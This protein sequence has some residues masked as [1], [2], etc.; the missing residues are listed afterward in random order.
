MRQINYK[1]PRTL[2]IILLVVLLI[3]AN[4]NANYKIVGNSELSAHSHFGWA[5][6]LD[7]GLSFIS[8][9][10]EDNEKGMDV[11]AVYTFNTNG[12]LQQKIIPESIKPYDNF[13]YSVSH[14]GTIAIVGAIG[15][16]TNGTFSGCVY[17]YRYDGQKWIEEQKL[18]ASDGQASDLFGCSVDIKG[19]IAVVGSRQS[20]G[21]TSKSGAAYIFEFD[22]TNWK[23]V[24]KLISS[25]SSPNDIFGHSVAINEDEVVVVG[26]YSNSG[27]ENNSGS[28]YI[29]E[30][31]QS[32]WSKTAKLVASD[33]KTSDLFGFSVAIS[34]NNILVGAYQNQLNNK[35]HG[36]V[37]VYTKSETSW[38]ETA[39]LVLEDG[40]E[41]DFFGI[42]VAIS[43][44]VIAIGSSRTETE[45]NKDVGSVHIYSLDSGTWINKSIL[46]PEIEQNNVQFGLAIDI[47]AGNTLVGSCLNDNEA[48]DSGTAYIF[49]NEVTNIK[50]EQNLPIVFELFQNYPNPFNP[51]TTIK[52]SIPETGFVTLILYDILGKEVMTLVGDTQKRGYYEQKFNAENFTSGIYFYRLKIDSKISDTK[53]MILLQ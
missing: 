30:K 45:N 16:R 7:N 43:D 31:D 48:L 32:I 11:G 20:T 21:G 26:A 12:E 6:S 22:G 28:V 37:Y 10:H 5:V 13:G 46:I 24:K 19:N 27:A 8:A 38:L 4:L 53:K 2:N 52:Y 49:D 15:D 44:S 23:E 50:D 40:N 33:G 9:P 18:V 3:S 42:S 29:F 47:E 36:A 1:L 51:T 35:H 25:D 41:H 39:K 14:Y 34:K 17:I